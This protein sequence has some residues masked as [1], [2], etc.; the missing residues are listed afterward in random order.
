L[1]AD[2][3]FL[4]AGFDFQKWKNDSLDSNFPIG[5]A[6]DTSTRTALTEKIKMKHFELIDKIMSVPVWLSI[7]VGF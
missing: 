6:V 5:Q 7:F 1:F 2:S 4:F 3:V